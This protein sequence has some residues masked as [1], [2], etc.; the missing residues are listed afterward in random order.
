MYKL[1]EAEQWAS[2]WVR[3]IVDRHRIKLLV[4]IY[5]I[6]SSQLRGPFT[7]LLHFPN[8]PNLAKVFVLGD[9]FYQR[10]TQHL[11]HRCLV[12][13]PL[14]ANEARFT[15]Q[16]CKATSSR[17]IGIQFGYKISCTNPNQGQKL[18]HFPLLAGDILP[19]GVENL[20]TE[21][22]ICPN[23]NRICVG[24]TENIKPI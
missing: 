5:H 23:F 19:E 14:K 21:Y 10:L 6:G 22:Y 2:Q 15:F 9:G 12:T 18:E 7:S 3:L 11:T 24:E 16:S 8:V 17:S 20:G 1:G 4:P 13:K